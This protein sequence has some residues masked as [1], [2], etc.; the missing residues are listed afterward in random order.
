MYGFVPITAAQALPA[1]AAAAVTGGAL[2]FSVEEENMLVEVAFTGCVAST[3]GG[4]LTFK[5]Q[6]DGA[7]IVNPATGI[8]ML[9]WIATWQ[10]AEKK[11]V[12]YKVKTTLSKGAHTLKLFAGAAVDGTILG[13]TTDC[14]LIADRFSADSTMGQ[15]VNSKVQFQE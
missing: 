8:A 10:A 9:P 5:F 1:G 13:T 3:A 2:K 4:D 6:V 11:Y 12:S 14:R 15:G 7:D